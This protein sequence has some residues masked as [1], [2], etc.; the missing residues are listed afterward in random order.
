MK[1]RLEGEALTYV[2]LLKVDLALNLLCMYSWFVCVDVAEVLQGH[3][4]VM[5]EQIDS[6]W[7]AASGQKLHYCGLESGWIASDKTDLD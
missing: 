7:A 1:K 6:K 4:A 2:D 3:K 5:H